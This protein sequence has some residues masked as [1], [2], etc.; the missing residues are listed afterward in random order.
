[1]YAK[2]WCGY[3]NKTK[4]L[5][6]GDEFKDIDISIIDL[7]KTEDGPALQKALAEIAGKTSVPQVFVNGEL[8]GGNDDTQEAYKSGELMQKIKA[9]A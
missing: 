1:M 2:T 9:Q 7:D 8:L 4:A 3:C 6:S 5:L